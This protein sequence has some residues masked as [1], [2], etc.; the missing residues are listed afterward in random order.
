MAEGNKDNKSG[1]NSPGSV[2]DTKPEGKDPITVKVESRDS[3]VYAKTVSDYQNKLEEARREAERLK[4]EQARNK[5]ELDELK[6]KE[7]SRVRAEKREAALLEKAENVDIKVKEFVN[8]TLDLPDEKYEKV[9]QHYVSVAKSKSA[10]SSENKGP[11]GDPIHNINGGGVTPEKPKDKLRGYFDRL[12]E[13]N[14][15]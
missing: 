5:E 8:D 15:Y 11:I 10:A 3:E 14:N 7:E 9:S 13:L 12:F 2:N 4:E 6:S 1:A